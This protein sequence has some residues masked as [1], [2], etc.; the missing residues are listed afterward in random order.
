MRS[1]CSVYRSYTEVNGD[2]Y[3]KLVVKQINCIQEIL[4]IDAL[5]KARVVYYVLILRHGYD[6]IHGKNLMKIE[7]LRK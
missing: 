6:D 2:L 4:Y 7:K 3:K 5:Y 1:T